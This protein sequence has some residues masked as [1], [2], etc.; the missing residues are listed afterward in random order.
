MAT[1]PGQSLLNTIANGGTLLGQQKIPGTNIQ[2][3]SGWYV[4]VGCV[5]AVLLAATPIAPIILA[6][7]SLA[8]LYQATQLIAGK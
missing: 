6:V 7:M 8:L 4:A 1:L 5:G 2:A 3:T